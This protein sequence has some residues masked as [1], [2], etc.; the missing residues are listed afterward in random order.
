MARDK[1]LEDSRLAD[2]AHERVRRAMQVDLE[3]RREHWSEQQE[4][5][6]A[7]A[8]LR[9]ALRKVL[10]KRAVA[11]RPYEEMLKRLE[12][13]PQVAPMWC[14]THEDWWLAGGS[15]A[16]SAWLAT[17]QRRAPDDKI[18][19]AAR[20][21]DD[22]EIAMIL[23]PAGYRRSRERAIAAVRVRRAVLNRRRDAAR[24]SDR[25]EHIAELEQLRTDEATS[26]GETSKRS[27]VAL[28]GRS[29]LR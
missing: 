4:L 20:E 5:R 1:L 19:G 9:A 22:D 8:A 2:D 14:R 12:R 15:L 13:E 11:G 25:S 7:V 10:G 26:T 28:G 21:L 23:S 27:A 24:S 29:R 6:R 17:V 3:W 18:T 16:P